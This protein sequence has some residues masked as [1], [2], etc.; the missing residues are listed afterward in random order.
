M[1]VPTCVV[2]CVVWALAWFALADKTMH[3]SANSL[4]AKT[5]TLYNIDP[6][7]DNHTWTRVF[8]INGTAQNNNTL[9]ASSIWDW[10]FTFED[11]SYFIPVVVVVGFLVLALIA[12]LCVWCSARARPTAPNISDLEIV[13][14][15]LFAVDRNGVI[16]A[17]LAQ[18]ANA[19]VV[20]TNKSVTNANLGCGTASST[21]A[22]P[23][24]RSKNASQDCKCACTKATPPASGWEGV[25]SGVFPPAELYAARSLMAST[26]L[27]QAVLASQPTQPTV[28]RNS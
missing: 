6:T 5:L 7:S 23:F 18:N 10:W 15:Q 4:N 28:S 8:A 22:P 1:H 11:A 21:S 26:V 3:V 13:G 2:N 14:G 24:D 20:I 17:A 19:A 12:V 25:N 16:A 9:S 27:D